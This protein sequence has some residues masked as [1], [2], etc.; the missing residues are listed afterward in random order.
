M[1][2]AMVMAHGDHVPPVAICKSK[3][4]TEEDIKASVPSA[5]EKL[6]EAGKITDSWKSAIVEK[7]ESKQM[8]KG[9]KWIVIVNNSGEKDQSKQRLYILI[10]KKG[11][12]NNANFTGEFQ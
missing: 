12:L 1:M 11:Y 9:S 5:I 2:P 8:K 3:T 7:V 6:I 10:N 4:C